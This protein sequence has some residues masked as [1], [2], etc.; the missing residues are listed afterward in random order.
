MPVSFFPTEMP[1]SNG[2]SSKIKGVL[3]LEKIVLIALIKPGDER[4]FTVS[5]Y[6]KSARRAACMY[7][8]ISAPLHGFHQGNNFQIS[9]GNADLF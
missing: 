3:T 6:F 1:S 9:F 5:V 2:I 7:E 8:K 4:Q